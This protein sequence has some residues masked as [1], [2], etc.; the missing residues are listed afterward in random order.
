MSGC[1]LGVF[2]EVIQECWIS[3]QVE[4]LVKESDRIRVCLSNQLAIVMGVSE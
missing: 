4:S 3:R 1:V 2:Q